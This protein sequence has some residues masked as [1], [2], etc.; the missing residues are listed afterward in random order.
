[1]S[2]AAIT[3]QYPVFPSVN[4]EEVK[5]PNFEISDFMRFC[6]EY[7]YIIDEGE[8]SSLFVLLSALKELAITMI[9]F[10]TIEDEKIYNYL[11]SMY[12]G[13]LLTMH[14]RN[15]KDESY[16]TSLQGEVIEKSYTVS[17][18][19]KMG[20][21]KNEYYLTPYG[22]QFYNRYDALVENFY[23]GSYSRRYKLGGY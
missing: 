23:K 8:N 7:R 2:W 13:H 22:I 11:L 4:N 5:K 17:S 10:N 3:I 6:P 18:F 12:I 21:E 20:K 1:M 14:I 16:A 15:L 19:D 9:P